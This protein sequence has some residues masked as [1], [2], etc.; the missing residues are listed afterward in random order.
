MAPPAAAS[1]RAVRAVKCRLCGTAPSTPCTSK[2]DHLARWLAA[3]AYGAISR[4]DLM[5]VVVRL[6]VVT[7][8]CLITDAAERT[9]DEPGRC[10]AVRDGQREVHDL[11]KCEHFLPCAGGAA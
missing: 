6:T 2:G 10:W 7:K 5:E 11:R 4:A 3:Y 1:A 8:W 9:Q